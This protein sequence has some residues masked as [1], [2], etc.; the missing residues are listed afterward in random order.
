MKTFSQFLIKGTIL[1]TA[2]LLFFS[3]KKDAEK[4]DPYIYQPFSAPIALPVAVAGDDQAI[5]LPVNSVSL[6]GT[7]RIQYGNFSRS[8]WKKLTGPFC[9]IEKPNDLT[10]V[11]S[12]LEEGFYLLELSVSDDFNREAKDTVVV[13]VIAPS[14]VEQSFSVTVGQSSTIFSSVKWIQPWYPTLEVPNIAGYLPNGVIKK[15][16]VQRANNNAWIEVPPVSSNLNS[17]NLYE[18]FIE[19]RL[20]D[21]AGMYSHGSLFVMLYNWTNDKTDDTPSIKVEY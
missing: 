10:T 5:Q 2:L 4:N 9:I 11:V 7:Y 21:G 1:I 14:V 8:T 12:K 16:Y 3:C 6:K 18:Y 13:R 15:V 20:P 17:N 19:T